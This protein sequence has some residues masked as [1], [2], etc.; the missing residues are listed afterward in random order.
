MNSEDR[1]LQKV[2]NVPA[3][4]TYDGSG[5][6]STGRTLVVGCSFGYKSNTRVF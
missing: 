6:D 3:E 4:I 1:K 5:G 2:K